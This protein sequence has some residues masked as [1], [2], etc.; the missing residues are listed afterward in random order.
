MLSFGSAQT[1]RNEPFPSEIGALP[2]T[3]AVHGSRVAIGALEIGGID[4]PVGKG[5][6]YR[7]TNSGSSYSHVSTRSQ[8]KLVAGLLTVGG[9]Y[10]YAEAWDQSISQPDYAA[11]Q[12]PAAIDAAPIGARCADRRMRQA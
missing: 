6:G 5:L 11:G 3:V 1:L 8:G 7:S 2:T 9:V 4:G 10:K 12:V